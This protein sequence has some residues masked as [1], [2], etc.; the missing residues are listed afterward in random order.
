MR[1][2]TLP[3]MRSQKLV[4]ITLILLGAPSI[5]Q[6]KDIEETVKEAVRR[7]TLNQVGTH[8]FHLRATIAPTM[9]SG[10]GTDRKGE[11]EI[12][13]QSPTQFKQEINSPEFH[14]IKIVAGDREW[15]ENEGVYFP[16][17]L[18]ETAV[19][20]IEPVPQLNQVLEQMKTGEVRSMAGSTYA[21]WMSFSTDGTVR[22]SIGCTVSVNNQTG[23]LFYGGCSGWGALFKNYADFHGRKVA[24]V[25]NS[26]SPEVTTTVAVLEDLKDVSSAI[27]NVPDEGGDVHPLH[28]VVVDEMSLRK[29][30]EPAPAL[31]WP[32]VKDGP[33]EGV[34]TTEIVLD[35]DGKVRDVS[36]VLSDNP[37]LSEFVS[38][39]VFAMKFKPYL[40]NGEPV[41]VVSRITMPFKTVRPAGVENFASART[42][43]EHGR[44]RGFPAAVASQPYVL[45]ATFR[46]K[47]AEGAV[48]EGNYTDT[49]QRVDE[50]RREATIGKSRYVRSQQGGKRYELAEGPDVFILR[51]VL[52]ALEPIPALDTFVESDWRMKRDDVSGTKT[53]RVLSGF[54]SSAGELDPE[55]ARGYWFDDSGTLLKTYFVGLE[56][57]RGQFVDFGNVSVAR[58]INVLSKSGVAMAIQVTQLSPGELDAKNNFEMRGHEHSRAFTDEVR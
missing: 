1:S 39:S 18:R 34:I 35:R 2:C 33:L 23:L 30:L 17:W 47:L 24:R 4:L 12:W 48:A 31:A 43:F 15:Q 28:T 20:L 11:V 51:L 42:Y 50:W 5:L 21:S 16:E 3:V 14:Q 54:E 32:P 10:P 58:Q 26:G 7:S 56:T 49:F 55:H 22:K 36:A 57:Q 44:A 53:I 13:W 45:Q 9:N 52:R 37:G 8:A 46:A 29:N 40:Q 19:A 27:F 25:L 6:G 41:Q 38:K